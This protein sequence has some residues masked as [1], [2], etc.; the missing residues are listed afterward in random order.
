MVFIQLGDAVVEVN[1]VLCL[2]VDTFQGVHGGYNV[3]VEIHN[4][5]NEI[6]G[7]STTVVG[8]SYVEAQGNL[9]KFMEI[10][11]NAKKTSTATPQ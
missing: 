9:V 7:M 5:A 1:T 11:N 4:G 3:F 10:V 8:T 6:R 2:Y